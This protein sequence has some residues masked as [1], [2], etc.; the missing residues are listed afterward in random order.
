MAR[1][2]TP[3]RHASLQAAGFSTHPLAIYLL[4]RYNECGR[5][6]NAAFVI[7]ARG[8]SEARAMAAQRHCDEP[9][10]SWTDREL[11]ACRFLGFHVDRGRAAH[12]ICTDNFEG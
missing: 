5:D 7:A 2:T 6:E 1:C 3:E 4:A 11:S 10:E 12:V 8:E 9:A